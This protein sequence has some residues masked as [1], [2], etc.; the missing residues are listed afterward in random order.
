MTGAEV[1][2]VAFLSIGVNWTLLGVGSA[3]YSLVR[4]VMLEAPIRQH[5]GWG[6][7]A[8]CMRITAAGGVAAA[9]GIVLMM[10]LRD[11]GAR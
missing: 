10:V 5:L 9:I 8:W 7:V 1:T 6:M 11:A 4:F 2:A 3:L